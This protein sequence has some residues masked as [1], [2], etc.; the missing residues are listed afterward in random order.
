MFKV[1]G[2][3]NRIHVEFGEVYTYEYWS[4]GWKLGIMGGGETEQGIYERMLLVACP[5][6]GAFEKRGIEIEVVNE[7]AG[8][9]VGGF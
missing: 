9:T 5:R 1:N 2:K 8:V 4:E 6:T 7:G 3:I